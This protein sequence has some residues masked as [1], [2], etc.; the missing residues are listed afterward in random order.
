MTMHCQFL[1][2]SMRL[3]GQRGDFLRSELRGVDLI[4]H[5]QDSARDRCLDYIGSILDQIPDGAAD[6]VGTVCD[7]I[8]EV[9]LPAEEVVAKTIGIVK[10]ATSRSHT[11]GRNKHSRTNDGAI[12]NR[13][14]QSDIDKI[15]RPYITDR[16][17]SCLD[18]DT[19]A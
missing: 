13:V 15:A 18:G 11:L 12:G 2:Q 5:R 9:G 7:S 6:G 8:R 19:R 17:E 1:P 10:M 14:A 16:C 4:R 3:V